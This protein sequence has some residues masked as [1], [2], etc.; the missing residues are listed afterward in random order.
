MQ[1]VA[2]EF[3]RRAEMCRRNGETASSNRDKV[4]WL[5]LADEWHRLAEEVDPK[6]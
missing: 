1:D 5:E 6:G 4:D 3:L 2:A